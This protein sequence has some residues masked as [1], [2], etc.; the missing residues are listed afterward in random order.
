S[1]CDKGS[2]K[3]ASASSKSSAESRKSGAASAAPKTTASGNAATTTTASVASSATGAAKKSAKERLIGGWVFTEDT[4]T[5]LANKAGDEEAKKAIRDEAAN[6]THEWASDGK[7]HEQS[8][9]EKK[10]ATWEVVKEDGD[11]IVT[12]EKNQNG[13]EEEVKI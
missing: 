5:K 3:A 4:M 11:T 10:E 13:E 9:T 6:T 12:K 7:S 8:G 1:A 2:N